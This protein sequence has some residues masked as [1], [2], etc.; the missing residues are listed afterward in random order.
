MNTFMN[1]LKNDTNYKYTENGGIAHK[2][3]NSAVYDLFAFG[4][5]Y[6]K[7]S[8]DDCILLFKNALE[9]NT[10]LAMKCLFWIRDCRGGAGE[11]RFFRTCI[12]WLAKEHPEIIKRNLN[13]IP[14]MGRWDDLYEL[15]DSTLE[16]DIFDIIKIQLEKDMKDIMSGK[17]NIGISL[18]AKWLK[19]ENASSVETKRLAKKTR[20][21]LGVSAKAYRKTLSNLREHIKVLERLMSEGR[22][23]EI[24][25]SKIPSK[26]G[27]MYR[28][29][30]A[31]RDIIA[32][33]YKAFA[34]DKTSKVNAATLYPY[35][36]VEKA[37]KLF[38]SSKDS[39]ERLMVNKYWDSLPDYFNGANCNMMC[40]VDTSGSMI[41]TP[42]DVAIS[43]G[44]YCAERLNGAFHNNYI[45]FSSRPQLINIA[46]I[47]F[48]DKVHR[49]YKTNLCDNT[50]LVAVFDL[51]LSIAR[52]PEVKKEDIP[53]TIV[54]ISD[55]E[56]DEG[57]SMGWWYSKKDNMSRWTKETAATEMEAVRQ[58]WASYGFELPRLI[59][60]NV[61]SRNS[62][63]ILDSGPNVSFVSGFSP[64]IFK[65]VLT[66]KNG[67]Q[68]MIET[69]C[70]EKYQSI[71]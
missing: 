62:N 13:F 6:R 69:I 14:E 51:L 23:E 33:K 71:K 25:F 42:I 60:W 68:L 57:T 44:M 10:E 36:I 20:K 63:T 4:S 29:A 16:N 46:G 54:V 61:E 43:L 40:V 59:Y 47:D 15:V 11:R 45:S 1:Q 53:N 64:T 30:F 56:I 49:I 41:G 24:D 65:S 17:S 70:A 8:D 58:K 22:W 37:R 2:S 32:E 27:L 38:S 3:T 5:A 50:N 26:A 28:N 39:T 34:K 55:M 35:E 67:Y 12:K 9:E 52:H 31:R 7:R 48:V 21:A 19:S 18:L 66:G